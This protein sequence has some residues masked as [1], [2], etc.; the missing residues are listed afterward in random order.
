MSARAAMVENDDPRAVRTRQRLTVAYRDLVAGG[1]APKSVSDVT[2][3]A[4]VNRPTFYAHFANID[5]LALYSLDSFLAELVER[6]RIIREQLSA[7]AAVRASMSEFVAH[8]EKERATYSHVLDIRSG[9]V[10]Y[11]SIVELLTSTYRNLFAE[12]AVDAQPVVLEMTARFTAAGI[13]G[14]LA[15]W[16]ADDPQSLSAEGVVDRLLTLL[17]DWATSSAASAADPDREPRSTSGK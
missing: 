6:D 16:L 14:A 15:A 5:E 11:A 2:A 17:P 4:K 8:V 12:I 13:C 9:G 1:A 3:R 10:A 7:T